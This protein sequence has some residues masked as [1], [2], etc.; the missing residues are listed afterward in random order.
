M[1][2]EMVGRGLAEL[3]LAFM[4]LQPFGSH[5]KL[6][7]AAALAFYWRERERIEQPMVSAGERDRR[8]R[9]ADALWA[10]WLI[11][12]AHKMAHY[13][14]PPASPPRIYWESMFAVLADRLAAFNYD[15]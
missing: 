15:S 7:R 6:D 1:D 3:D 9:Y 8:Q 5:R 11:P 2:W 10:L 14:F 13:P 4:F 12:V